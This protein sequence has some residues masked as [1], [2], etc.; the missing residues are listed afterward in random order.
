MTGYAV[1]A[2]LGGGYDH[3]TPGKYR[4]TVQGG[5]DW[6]IAN[7]IEDG[8]F[9]KGRNYENGICAMALA[10]AYAMTLDPALREPAQKG[11]DHILSVQ[12]G[13]DQA[14][15]GGGAWDY[16]VATGRE[17]SSVSGW[18]IM[19][20]KSAKAGDLNVG[21]GMDK[22]STWFKQTWEGAN[23]QEGLN[24][25]DPYEDVSIFPY[26]KNKSGQFRH[27]GHGTTARK[28]ELAQQLDSVL[29]FS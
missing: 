5:I 7:Q 11:I 19:A 21:N 25:S 29:V 12:G 13:G 9:G 2:F 24:P 15:E 8:S 20:L 4:A 17:D 28:G 10:E 14:Y 23:A 6:L 22:A 1:L 3:R 26:E 27:V 18:C 16:T